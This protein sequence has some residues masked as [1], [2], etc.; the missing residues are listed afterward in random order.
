M[1]R[2][3]RILPALLLLIRALPAAWAD[4]IGIVQAPE[5]SSGICAGKSAKEAFACAIRKCV[6]G[7]A[8]ARKPNLP[9]S[10][11]ATRRA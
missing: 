6:A 1:R 2:I 5:Q 11:L 9:A 10:W 8:A 7:G 3:G 4:G